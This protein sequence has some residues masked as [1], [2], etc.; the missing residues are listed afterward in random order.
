VFAQAALGFGWGEIALRGGLL[1][2]A[3]AII[4]N[5]WARKP[6]T[7]WRNVFY[8]WLAVVSYQAVRNTSFYLVPLVL[9]RFLPLLLIVRIGEWLVDGIANPRSSPR[10]VGQLRP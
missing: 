2:F 4:H 1:G 5:W 7:L 9:Y 10:T 8:I 3:L 6:V